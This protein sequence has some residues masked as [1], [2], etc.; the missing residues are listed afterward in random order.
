MKKYIYIAA[1]LLVLGG[2]SLDI[3]ESPN[4]PSSEDMNATLIFP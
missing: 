4:S 3:N 1:S 2:C